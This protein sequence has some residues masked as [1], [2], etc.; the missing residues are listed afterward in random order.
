MTYGAVWLLTSVL[1]PVGIIWAL[2]IGGATW[3]ENVQNGQLYLLALALLAGSAGAELM[4]KSDTNFG[5]LYLALIIVASV[6][7]AAAYYSSTRDSVSEM[8]ERVVLLSDE[9]IVASQ[10]FLIAAAAMGCTTAFRQMFCQ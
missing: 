6:V 2:V 4:I 3:Q 10:Y 5:P 8:S 9:S 1:L 7:C